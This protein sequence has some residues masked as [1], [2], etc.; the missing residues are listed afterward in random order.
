[1]IRQTDAFEAS[2]FGEFI[3]TRYT[4]TLCKDISLFHYAPGT[5]QSGLIQFIKARSACQ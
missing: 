3:V 5:A 1:M 4:L 2:L